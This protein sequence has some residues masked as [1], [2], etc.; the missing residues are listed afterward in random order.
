MRRRSWA[1]SIPLLLSSGVA[2]ALTV[3]GY[4]TYGGAANDAGSGIAVT[5][6]RIYFS[7]S[8]SD[9]AEGLVGEF[10]AALPATPT[11]TR[12]WPTLA[13]ADYFTGIALSNNG[14]YVSGTSYAR[15][16]DLVGGK[17]A[18]GITVRFNLDGSAGAGYG[19]NV[20]ERQ[21]PPAP[22]GFS[23][24]GYEFLTGITSATQA[25]QAFVFSVGFGQVSGCDCWGS[26]VDKF[27]EAGNRLWT[28]S[29]STTATYT[30]LRSSV[31]ASAD[32]VYVATS[33]GNP[34]TK[35]YI[36]K[37]DAAGTLQW[38]RTSTASGSYRGV[39]LSGTTVIAVG[40]APLSAGATDF[41]IEAW[42]SAGNPLWSRTYDAGGTTETLDGVVVLD[43]RVYAVGAVTPAGTGAKSDGII[44][45]VNLTT[46]DLIGS[47]TWGGTD[48]DSFSGIAAAQLDVGPRLFV[49]GT[50]KSYGNGGSD[51][52][53]LRVDVER[54][55]GAWQAIL[56]PTVAR[57]SH[58]ATLLRDNRVLVSG[59]R[60][61]SAAVASAEVYDPVANV[62][63]A[64]GDSLTARFD[65]TATLLA[66]GRVLAAGGVGNNASCT[67]N[68]TSEVYDPINGTWVVGPSAPVPFGTGHSAIRLNNGR[69]LVSGGGNR[70]G[71]VFRS[72]ALFDPNTSSWTRTGDMTAAREFHSSTLLPDGR[73]LVAGGVG[74]NSLFLSIASAEIYDPA[75]GQ[76][77]AVPAMATPRSTSCN[78]YMEPFLATLPNGKVMAAAGYRTIAPSGCLNGH[79]RSLSA[80][81][82]VFDVASLTW[83]PAAPLSTPRA[84]TTLTPL[85]DGRV[86]VAGGTDGTQDL[87]TAELFNP[88][89]G[90]WDGAA[91][92]SI[93][94][95]THS[96]TRLVDG[97]VLVI[98]GNT[99]EVFS[100]GSPPPANRP[101]VANP[102]VSRQ[103]KTGVLVALDGRGSYD[104]EGQPL[105][106]SWSFLSRPAGSAAALANAATLQP[107]FVPDVDGQYRVRL[108][109]T[110]P[111]G[112]AASALITLTASANRAPVA[113]IAP[114][115]GSMKVP[116]DKIIDGSGS[117]DPDGDPLR[118]Y[119]WRLVSKPPN[120]KG[121][122][123]LAG[124]QPLTG[125]SDASGLCSIAVLPGTTGA[126][127]QATLVMDIP[128]DY[129]VELTVF[130]NRCL[131]G[132]TRVTIS[133]VSGGSK[134]PSP[135]SPP[136]MNCTIRSGVAPG[137][138]NPVQYVECN[139]QRVSRYAYTTGSPLESLSGVGVA[140]NAQ[141]VAY[142]IYK[143]KSTTGLMEEQTRY[144][145]N[146]TRN[147]GAAPTEITG[148]ARKN[149]AS[150]PDE[151]I[152]DFKITGN[153]VTSKV[154]TVS[155]QNCRSS[156]K[157]L[158]SGCSLGN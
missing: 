158:P 84:L 32:A 86:L 96:A 25:G 99:A 11:W 102:G 108:N 36:R 150:S 72:A 3:E 103:I 95:S 121:M 146:C 106:V 148:V 113:V 20:W 51:V 28:R 101:P 105:T 6:S 17:E 76:W 64:T 118:K 47:K 30:L 97:R 137:T 68:A 132:Q 29:D 7:G 31:A 19:G 4:T 127:Y 55:L 21:T 136:A 122:L 144:V 77:T 75:T 48:D 152:R 56:G 133:G 57:V 94:R 8:I 147:P 40:Q 18:K 78:G 53:I 140:A 9:S 142:W 71:T 135:P 125:S 98:S 109:V 15:T 82:E 139:G 61:G 5:G 149:R 117:S 104:P 23:Y 74:Q 107:S 39:T 22:G 66:D 62:W 73:V 157:S 100:L 70:C 50:T 33:R 14:A 43:G 34:A 24:G 151:E 93:P 126:S 52:A 116:V 89:T 69:V 115:T 46:G 67:T 92:M 124:W 35:P 88:A 154:C 145:A 80:L 59:G 128:G 134:P 138:S 1:L 141:S 12:T 26:F 129:I 120:S 111:Q 41:L 87:D 156:T 2:S 131:S 38:T 65:H 10:P 114:V 16:T 27:D 79:T 42:D 119:D 37:Y 130:D 81:A 63:A 90:T 58:Q 83:A 143:T 45:E 13:S 112:A 91:A 44:L 110:D 60:S 54:Q 153:V 123:R 49:V 155:G 85:L